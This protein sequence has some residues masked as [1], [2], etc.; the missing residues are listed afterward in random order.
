MPLVHLCHPI[1]D[2]IRVIEGV[3]GLQIEIRLKEEL[4]EQS[5]TLVFKVPFPRNRGNIE[6]VT[7][8]TRYP[9]PKICLVL[10]LSLNAEG[11]LCVRDD[12]TLLSE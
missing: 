9:L 4:A 5:D 8:P 10:K 3:L 6:R 1:A 12:A 2:I 11:I 7:G